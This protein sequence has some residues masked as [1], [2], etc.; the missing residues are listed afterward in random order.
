[1]GHRGTIGS[2]VQGPR[3]NAV[4]PN[5]RGSQF[6][7]HA[8]RQAKQ[9]C[10]R[11]AVGGNPGAAAESGNRSN[12]YD[13]APAPVDHGRDRRPAHQQGGAEI[14]LQ[15]PI[16]GLQWGLVDRR[17]AFESAGDIDQCVDASEFPERV[18]HDLGRP[19]GLRQI[20][21]ER[22]DL[23]RQPIGAESLSNPVQVSTGQHQPRTARGQRAGHDLSQGPRASRHHHDPSLQPLPVTHLLLALR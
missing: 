14:Q 13:A 5:S 17:P 2:R 15:H 20:C 4:D 18:P 9:G 11:R 22:K 10:L 6:F 7:R 8:L 16:P 3:Q 19:R 23:I 12:V 21:L 1:M